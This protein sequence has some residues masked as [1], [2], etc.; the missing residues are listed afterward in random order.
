MSADKYEPIGFAMTSR[1]DVRPA[2]HL[3]CLISAAALTWA[4][5]ALFVW[6][7]AAAATPAANRTGSDQGKPGQTTIQI[8]NMH[9]KSCTKKI[10]GKLYAVRGVMRVQTNIKKNIAVVT[11]QP[12]KKLDVMALWN[13][14][15][16]AGFEP[17]KLVGPDGTY[18]PKKGTKTAQRVTPQAQLAK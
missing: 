7:I 18:L 15:Q 11:A 2:L 10:A 14:I 16:A 5:P 3:L 1:N 4:M 12:K 8:R 6:S 17:Q 13:A 9:C